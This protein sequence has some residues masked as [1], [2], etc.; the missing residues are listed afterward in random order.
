MTYKLNPCPFCGGPA[1]LDCHRSFRS[2]TDGR[3]EKAIAVYCTDCSADISVC[4]SDVPDIQPEQL[5][6]MWNRRTL[7]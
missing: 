6:E 4:Y 1:D 3:I 7:S 5:I 2:I